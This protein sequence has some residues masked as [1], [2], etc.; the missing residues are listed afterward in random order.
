MKKIIIFLLL[1]SLV[2]SM[3]PPGKIDAE[4]FAVSGE[5]DQ[6][7]QA[8]EDQG[9]LSI[10]NLSTAFGV[11]AEDISF[12]LNY[13]YT[14][15]EIY[16]ALKQRQQDGTAFQTHLEQ[17][18][19]SVKQ[20]QNELMRMIEET[21]KYQ[22]VTDSTYSS[23]ESN[24][25]SMTTSER[26]TT[27]TLT[28]STVTDS[29]Y[30]TLK[31]MGVTST[32]ERPST[33]D[34]SVLNRLEVKSDQAP[35]S[36]ANGN[37]AISTLS[38]NL[39]LSYTDLTLP[40]RNG[41][42]FYLTRKYDSSESNFFEKNVD[43][44]QLWNNRFLPKF[45]YFIYYYPNGK[46]RAP[47]ES[48]GYMI[49]NLRYDYY[50]STLDRTVGANREDS[51]WS[52]RFYYVYAYGIPELE[53]KKL[54][55]GLYKATNPQVDDPMIWY[56]FSLQA[57]YG[58]VGFVAKMYPTGEVISQG[59]DF[60]GLGVRN[61]ARATKVSPLG[62]GWDW[63]I[64]EIESKNNHIYLR[65][66]GGAT[67]EIGSN[68]NLIGYPWKDLNLT[69]DTSVVV[70]GKTSYRR[71]TSLQGIKQYFSPEGKLIQTSD[72]YG[73]SIQYNYAIV[74]PYGE[75]LTK[76]VDALGNQ[77]NISYSATEVTATMGDKVVRY[78][79]RLAP[80]TD[81]ELLDSATDAGGRTLR[82]SYDVF[83][84]SFNLLPHYYEPENNFYALLKGVEHPTGART[85]YSYEKQSRTVGKQ[86]ES[87]E[88]YR[89]HSREDVLYNVDGTVKQ[90]SNRVTFTGGD[91]SYGY[92]T[93]F[94]TTTDNGLF[95]TIY[96]YKKQYID[97]NTPPVYYNTDIVQEAGADKRSI[98]QTF[99]ETRKLPVPNDVT[100]TV[101]SNAVT[102]E[103][104]TVK[105]TYDDYGNVVTETDPK[106]VTT[107]YAYDP[108]T[109][110]QTSI[111]RPVA[112]GI[113]SYTELIRNTQ[114]NVTQL[115]VRENL[116]TGTLKQQVNYGYDP[117][118]N[119]TLITIRDDSRNVSISQEYG[120]NAGFVT[121]QTMNV[122]DAD[123]EVSSITRQAEYNKLTGDLT[124]YIDSKDNATKYEYDALGRITKEVLP[125]Q[126]YTA[127]EYDD[128]NN[129]V[130][131][132]DLAGI[133]S[134]RKYNA[135]GQIE[136]ETIGQNYKTY[137]YDAYGRQ[138]WSMDANNRRT[139]TAYD[140]WNRVIQVSFPGLVNPDT[141]T[142][143]YDD[144]NRTKT[145]TDAESNHYRETY[146]IS[147]Q[148]LKKE[149][150][151]ATGN[152]LLGIYSYDYAGHPITITDGNG[153]QTKNQYDILGRLI[154][155][156]D[157]LSNIH[158]YTYSLAGNLVEMIYPDGNKIQKHYDETGKVIKRIDPS[159]QMD[160]Y[161][162][163]GNGNVIRH[164]DRKG[165]VK[166]FEYDAQRDFLTKS[167]TPQETISYSYDA[168]GR[169]LT[170]TDNTGMTQYKYEQATGYLHEI[171]YA[172]GRTIQYQ[173]DTLGNRTSST[174]PFG[175]TTAYG[176]DIRYRLNGVGNAVNNWEA[177]YT[178]KK[179]G[180]TDV[181]SLKNGMNSTY[182]FDGANLISLVQNKSNGI[183]VNTF[184]YSYDNNYNQ[185]GKTENGTSF[186]FG[187]D[188]LNRIA[189]S[190][191]FQE[192]Y[193]YDSRGNRQTMHRNQQINPTDASYDYDDRN[194]L[195]KVTLSG[196]KVVSYKYNGDGLLYER[197]EGGQTTRY[198][199]D[200]SSVIAE[201]MVQT[202][203]KAVL[204]AR[205]LR[206]NGLVARVDASGNKTYY[207][208]NGHGDIIGLA[209]VNG[210]TLNTYSYDIWGNPTSTV[211]QVQQPFRY[212][213]EYWDS[214]TGLQYL[215]ARWYDPSIGRFIN[216]D[217]YEGDITNPLSL[218]LYTYVENN[219][220]RYVDPTGHVKVSDNDDL[221]ALTDVFTK[222]WDSYQKSINTLQQS[223][224]TCN[225]TVSCRQAQSNLDIIE[226]Y[227]ELQKGLEM[228][229]D[230]VRVTYY[231]IH[232]TGLPSDVKY[233][234]SGVDAPDIT[235][236]FNGLMNGFKADYGGYEADAATKLKTFWGVVETGSRVD[237]KNSV[238][239]HS[240]YYTFENEMYR[241][242]DLGNIYF[243]YAGKVFG[244]SD[245]FL[246]A[247]AGVYQ[248]YS[249]TSQVSYYSSW[250][251]DP[252]DQAMIQLGISIYGR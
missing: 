237:V 191:Q 127:I 57:R 88:Y 245:T 117:Y 121:K 20:K 54:E 101:T 188:K 224:S 174:D 167:I 205:Y 166:T 164:V 46:D 22:S 114:G 137:G 95:K 239:K 92:S 160:K 153:N 165:Q 155:V 241:R 233:R 230:A 94:H 79:K 187:Y 50:G 55:T 66:Q 30:G 74:P 100:S 223:I 173:Y 222:K 180:L 2:S 198:Y 89:V 119:V 81:K 53:R 116:N 216:E 52:G 185:T 63:D 193:T 159:G 10:S 39:N 96:T 35:Y 183:N 220:L 195:I 38:G 87:E 209:D 70:N 32:S 6:V 150:V 206:G 109:H 210:N 34:E 45:H 202:D 108:N 175:F 225:N 40:G 29:T 179:N 90:K 123:N 232:N 140:A 240:N 146:D 24:A 86:S 69:S 177:S 199:Y 196:G 91:T 27:Y 128:R 170:M 61:A 130:T 12:A 189:T 176:Y 37:E 182:G 48:E 42:S 147:G 200:G 41:L 64:P 213:G 71:L 103:A 246:K 8:N 31:S 168:A 76:V 181:V 85:E 110:L 132:T 194:R 163:D 65:L 49:N 4:T 84:G 151:K 242:D 9:I 228:M 231:K 152:V 156:T 102:S 118:G 171:T 124:K 212:S 126:N 251:D 125:D 252:R 7:I 158:R 67:Y 135:I 248:I 249:G 104:V 178:Y 243:G 112:D 72:A 93:N 115:T 16:Q 211:E 190:T 221:I 83:A 142:I 62:R 56:F 97:E 44:V 162:Y 77:I 68:N 157:P 122:T 98:K 120:Y 26:E 148:L 129:I 238:F 184:G 75:V 15:T 149:W 138:I 154:S 36:V 3:L 204:K 247:G 134:V 60:Q 133:K 51:E 21:V 186:S 197:T 14:L 143:T 18:N 236:Q 131:V 105:R 99:D 208:H 144:I 80:G 1:M 244:Y 141:E 250:F 172:D 11:A 203:G 145:T 111:L 73:N 229:A 214:S 136:K 235:N 28:K 192:S 25:T 5:S 169:R 82:Y 207:L 139:E 33:Y 106:N 107:T 215:R 78:T 19:P 217:S 201:G 219:P 113:S 23:K 13:G 43:V 17:I 59:G 218:N 161:Y 234:D 227:K 226:G 58:K 47:G